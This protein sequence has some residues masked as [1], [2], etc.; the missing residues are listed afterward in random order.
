[1]SELERDAERRPGD[2]PPRAA[3]AE[4]RPPAG[5]ELSAVAAERVSTGPDGR[6]WEVQPKWRRD[7]PIDLPRDEYVARRDFTKFMVLIS[8]GFVV[9]QFWI[10]FQNALRRRT[11][12]PPV[13][14]VARVDAVP[15]G[16]SLV[17]EYPEAGWE[18]ILVRLD[19]SRFV[20][21]DQSC[22]HLQCPVLAQVD[23]GRFYC[24]CHEGV[25]DLESGRPIAGPPERPLTRIVLDVRGGY[26][27]AT[28]LE[29][30]T[31]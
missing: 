5:T 21:F 18:A 9:G 15:V 10:L 11:G 25:F 29:R 3:G 16:G 6:G 14:R 4:A 22:T 27:Y 7:F 26:V 30:R 2:A 1:M 8:L 24:P 13:R 12:A 28:G 19:E 23:R 31:G 17:F 20:A